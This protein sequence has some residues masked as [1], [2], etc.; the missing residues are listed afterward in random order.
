VAMD[1]KDIDKLQGILVYYHSY[2]E[3]KK[4]LDLF[5]ENTESVEAADQE[6]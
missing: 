5:S 1:Q 4:I 3:W 6:S 2:V